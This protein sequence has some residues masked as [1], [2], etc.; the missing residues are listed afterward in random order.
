MAQDSAASKRLIGLWE[1]VGRLHPVLAEPVAWQVGSLNASVRE[2]FRFFEDGSFLFGR[3]LRDAIVSFDESKR[4]FVCDGHTDKILHGI[5][6]IEGTRLM[7]EFPMEGQPPESRAVELGALSDDRFVMNEQTPIPTL[8]FKSSIKRC[9]GWPPR[10]RSLPPIR[11]L[12]RS[13]RLA[14]RTGAGLIP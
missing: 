12:S 5:W 8:F 13:C 6:R 14:P 4:E 10:L 1:Q 7:E 11:P 2:Y 9:R 3:F